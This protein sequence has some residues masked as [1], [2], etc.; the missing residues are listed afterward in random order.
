VD[1]DIDRG[2]D[3]VGLLSRFPPC[4]P[5][6]IVPMGSSSLDEGATPM[7]PSMGEAGN[8]I[9]PMRFRLGGIEPQR[10]MGPP[11]FLYSFS[12]SFSFPSSE[13]TSRIVTMLRHWDKSK[14]RR[15]AESLVIQQESCPPHDPQQATP[16]PFG[17]M[18]K[19]VTARTSPGRAPFT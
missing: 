3:P 2:S 10:S 13:S 8:V 9:G 17:R 4:F 18:S 19:S 6:G 12:L 1:R 16:I 14:N 7:T 15:V 5:A 11:L